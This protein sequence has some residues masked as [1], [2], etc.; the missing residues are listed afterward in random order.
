MTITRLRS[1]RD[2]LIQRVQ[3]IIYEYDSAFEN[4]SD[5]AEDNSTF[6]ERFE[7]VIAKGEEYLDRL[8]A[9]HIHLKSSSV[10]Y[11]VRKINETRKDIGTIIRKADK[12]LN[13]L[14]Q[15]AQGDQ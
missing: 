10:K 12:L 15:M 14:V 13:K 6:S 2:S 9:I 3:T 1:E 7:T 4:I 5:V 8:R 11:S